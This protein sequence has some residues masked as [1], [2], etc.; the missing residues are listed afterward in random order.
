MLGYIR[1]TTTE[2]GLTVK[3][4][5]DENHYKKGQ[6]VKRKDWTSGGICAGIY[7]YA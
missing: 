6:P 5:L 2:T 1:G 7:G 3:A 4:Y